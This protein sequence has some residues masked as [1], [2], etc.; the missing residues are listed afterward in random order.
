MSPGKSFRGGSGPQ[1][2]AELSW[3][4]VG[5]ACKDRREMAPASGPDLLRDFRDFKIRLLKR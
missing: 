4:H 1:G 3:G 2:K 5:M